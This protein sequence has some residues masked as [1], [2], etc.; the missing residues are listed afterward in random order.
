MFSQSL[1]SYLVRRNGGGGGED[2][3]RLGVLENGLNEQLLSLPDLVL[4]CGASIGSRL[5][6]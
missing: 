3:L 4:R 2:R 1:V 6:I 5:N